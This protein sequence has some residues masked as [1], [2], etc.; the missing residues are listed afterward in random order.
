MLQNLQLP[1]FQDFAVSW[2]CRLQVWGLLDKQPQVFKLK[3]DIS[4]IWN[5]VNSP[6]AASNP[7]TPCWWKA[8]NPNIPGTARSPPWLLTQ[9]HTGPPQRPDR[10][11]GCPTDKCQNR[12]QPAGGRDPGQNKRVA[13]GWNA[14]S[15]CRCG[16]KREVLLESGT[17]WK[18]FLLGRQILGLKA[19]ASLHEYSQTKLELVKINPKPSNCKKPTH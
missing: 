13:W 11:Q 4:C 14:V 6:S 18:S 19:I 16:L 10:S 8:A 1:C 3:N 17:L 5:E 7:F 12:G 2:G 15:T 9:G